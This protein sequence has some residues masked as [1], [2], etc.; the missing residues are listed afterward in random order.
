[1]S[2]ILNPF[3]AVIRRVLSLQRELDQRLTTQID[4]WLGHRSRGYLTYARDTIPCLGKRGTT[5]AT[6]VN[7]SLGLRKDCERF[8]G[9]A[10]GRRIRSI[11]QS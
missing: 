10:S 7:K 3:L 8:H 11:T 6:V 9:H 5:V 4:A 1:M 2:V